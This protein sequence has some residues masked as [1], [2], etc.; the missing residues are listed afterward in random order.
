MEMGVGI[1]VGSGVDGAIGGGA[2]VG[3]LPPPQATAMRAASSRQG[4]NRIFN[5]RMGVFQIRV[6]I[7]SK[8][9]V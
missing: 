9:L 2:G 7:V 3:A 4:R 5:R 1:D 6:G 8:E